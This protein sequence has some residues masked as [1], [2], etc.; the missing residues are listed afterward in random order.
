[1]YFLIHAQMGVPVANVNQRG[2]VYFSD[3]GF[4]GAPWWGVVV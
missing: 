3:L 1:M 4:S 2:K